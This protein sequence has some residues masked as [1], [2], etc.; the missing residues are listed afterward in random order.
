MAPGRYQRLI[1]LSDLA[2]ISWGLKDRTSFSRYNGLENISISIQKQAEANTVAVSKA[3]KEAMEDL[4]ISLPRSMELSV[5]YDESEYILAALSNMRNNVLFGGILAIFV[6]LYFL[7]NFR[8]A[9]NV[10]LPGPSLVAKPKSNC[11]WLLMRI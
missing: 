10:G 5:T 9:M 8:D 6:L 11:P 7:G 2:E 3:V 1:P 4:K